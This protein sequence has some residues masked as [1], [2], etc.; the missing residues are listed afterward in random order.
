MKSKVLV[1]L[2]GIIAMLSVPLAVATGSIE[3]VTVQ[4][5]GTGSS[6]GTATASALSSAVAQVNGAEIAS[7]TLST[8]MTKTLDNY[9]GSGA[10]SDFAAASATVEAIA[11]QT[12][13]LVQSYRILSKAENAGIWT[14]S[15]EATISKY[16]KS[17]QA[18]RLRMTVLPFRTHGADHGNI[19][20]RF[21]ADLTTNLTSSRKFA[22][23]DRAFEGERQSEMGVISSEGTSM[24]EMAKLGNRLGTDYM[25]VGVIDDA[26]IHTQTA[27]LA[28]RTLTAKSATLSI[29]YRVIDAPTG[30]IKMADSWTGEMQGGAL[31]GLAAKAA[32]AIS[33]QIVD[34]I[35]PIKVESILGDQLFLGQGGKS[36]KVGQQYRLLLAGDVIVDS[37]TKESLGRQE[38]EVGLIEVIEVQSKIA[39]AK[40]LK[41]NV[42][43]ADKFPTS[44]FIVR[45][46]SEAA[47]PASAGVSSKKT[48]P[49]TALKKKVENDW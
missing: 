2:T 36:I 14:V 20:D 11:Q 5:E 34:S 28:G 8:E 7:N 12:K 22:M 31:E 39:K 44:T 9:S 37:Y 24:E 27:E 46:Q 29:S 26:S 4:T 23:L 18:D 40:I 48:A 49:V 13:G 17:E 42:N 32:D 10:G 30:Q 47:K 3:R 35:A 19:S 33:R 21:V 6:A 1:A 38:I 15:V 41:S 16:A 43:I 45:L 25:I